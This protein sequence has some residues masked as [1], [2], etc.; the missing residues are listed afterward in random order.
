LQ[1]FG[2]N[3]KSRRQMLIFFYQKGELKY[4]LKRVMHFY[5][6]PVIEEI[7]PLNPKP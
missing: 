2:T 3:R 7:P 4:F 1:P 6:I 5:Q